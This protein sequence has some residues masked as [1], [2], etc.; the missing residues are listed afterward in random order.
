MNI[1]PFNFS[2]DTLTALL[3]LLI[4]GCLLILGG[5]AYKKFLSNKHCEKQLETVCG[6]VNEIQNNFNIFYFNFGTTHNISG[7]RTL[8]D[9]SEMPQF[10]QDFNRLY[11]F[12][13]EN[14]KNNENI[15]NW[16]F[17]IKYHSDPLLPKQIAD[18]LKSFNNFQWTSVKYNEIKNEKCIIIG[19]KGLIQSETPCS[20]IKNSPIENCK[21]FK[22]SV[23]DLRHAIEEW[24][25]LYGI[26]DLNITTS[27]QFKDK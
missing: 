8:L 16:D 15:F 14:E 19:N 21:G 27:H 25:Q 24:L 22:K 5:F 3:G 9:V 23:I 26:K 4:N 12:F 18:K 11:F 7:W 20:Y 2:I 1:C 13:K 17:F 10:D 6:L